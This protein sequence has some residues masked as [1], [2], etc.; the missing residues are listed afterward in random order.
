MVTRFPQDRIG[1]RHIEISIERSSCQVYLS[2]ACLLDPSPVDKV[3]YLLGL[4]H[5][6]PVATSRVHYDRPISTKLISYRS[7][8]LECPLCGSMK[9]DNK[10]DANSSNVPCH[11]VSVTKRM[12]RC[13]KE[14]CA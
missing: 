11:S 14:I 2:L 13:H 12:L 6:N 3:V 1:L 10:P 9:I 7:V 5:K 4:G 8:F